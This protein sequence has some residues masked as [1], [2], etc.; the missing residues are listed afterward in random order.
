MRSGDALLENRRLSW[1]LALCISLALV[2]IWESFDWTSNWAPDVL[3]GGLSP[4]SPYQLC[5]RT[6]T[7][8]VFALCSLPCVRMRLPRGRLA[9]VAGVII[10][11]VCAALRLGGAACSTVAVVIPAGILTGI[12]FALFLQAWFGSYCGDGR[13]LFVT[14]LLAY[15][16]G[17]ALNPRGMGSGDVA[18]VIASVLFPLAG[19][20]LFADAQRRAA[21]SHP[22]AA[23]AAERPTAKTRSF[24]LQATSLLLCNFASG[25]ASYATTVDPILHAYAVPFLSLTL[26]CGLVL[27]GFPRAEML[28]SGLVL[29]TSGCIVVILAAPEARAAASVLASVS[30]WLLLF[31]SLT[32]FYEQAPSI[33]GS[34]SALALRGFAMVYLSSAAA[35]VAGRFLGHMAAC[36]V[37]L[38]LLVVSF[39]MMFVDASRY[40]V[41]GGLRTEQPNDVAPLVESAGFVADRYNLT[42]SEREMLDCL[43]KGYSLKRSAEQM[44]ISE[45]AAK[46]HRHNLYQKMG[47]NSRQ[48]LIDLVE[49][50]RAA[51]GTAPL[52]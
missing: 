15:F 12:G 52:R 22:R 19:L 5:A 6:T 46:Y 40:R 9:F 43:A 42:A 41:A 4:N 3:M 50:Q 14:L 11:A 16:I 28:F 18:N 25:L 33:G 10:V 48:E 7:G 34:V 23:L 21:A 32:W 1:H 38:G 13:E 27:V 44:S 17:A 20:A 37:T 26:V 2:F 39:A 31:Y 36:A 49:K 51:G 47:I 24:W 35:D 8:V 30:F 29:F 45:G